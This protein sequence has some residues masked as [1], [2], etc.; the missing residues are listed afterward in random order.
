[1]GKSIILFPMNENLRVCPISR[2]RAKVAGFEMWKDNYLSP[3]GISVLDKCK[4]AEIG[5]TD[6]GSEDDKFEVP[7]K[8]CA[9]MICGVR[10]N[11]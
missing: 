9:R 5:E 11:G 8:V 4:A 1:M 10:I 7:C 6:T 2:G 3:G